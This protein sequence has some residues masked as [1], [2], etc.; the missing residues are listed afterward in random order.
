MTQ[1]QP[2]TTVDLLPGQKG[3]WR[4]LYHK[5]LATLGDGS[6]YLDLDRG[7]LPLSG[8]EEACFRPNGFDRVT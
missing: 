2:T 4:Q 3:F 1:A 8:K 5:M 7:Y 6:L